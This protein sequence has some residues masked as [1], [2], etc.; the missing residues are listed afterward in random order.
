[1]YH[2]LRLATRRCQQPASDELSKCHPRHQYILRLRPRPPQRQLY[3]LLPALRVLTG[4]RGL[5]R[6]R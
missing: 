4:Q 2:H 6:P 1:M 5:L 3:L